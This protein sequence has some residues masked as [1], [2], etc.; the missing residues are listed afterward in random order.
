MVI[1]ATGLVSCTAAVAEADPWI[2]LKVSWPVERHG[3]A[4]NLYLRGAGGG[5][6]ELRSDEVSGAL[7]ELV[8][9]DTPPDGDRTPD[10]SA[11]EAADRTVVLDAEMWEWK[12][13]PD[14]R[15]PARR[16][17]TMTTD[18]TLAVA[19]GQTTVWFGTAEPVR[20]AIAGTVRAGLT[21]QDEL[22]CVSVPT[23]EAVDP[24]FN[25]LA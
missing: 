19:G 9:I 5:Y 7:T 8:V 2:P 12:V 18:L 1:R 6:V 25:K 17:T 23:P 10:T 15:E 22:I 13:T 4:L 11:P 21:A 24:G 3:G 20:F 16:D 14:Y